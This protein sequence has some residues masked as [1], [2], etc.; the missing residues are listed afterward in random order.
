MYQFGGNALDRPTGSRSAWRLFDD[1]VDLDRQ[2]GSRLENAELSP[3]ERAR[4]RGLRLDAKEIAS[5]GR[6]D[7]QMPA[8]RRAH[9]QPPI[10]PRDLRRA[11]PIGERI[12]Q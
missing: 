2:M 6:V 5:D 11:G 10:R 4:W 8:I 7:V 12:I 9:A 1:K 3:V